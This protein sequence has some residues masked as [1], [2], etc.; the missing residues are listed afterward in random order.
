MS[1]FSGCSGSFTESSLSFCDTFL[2]IWRIKWTWLFL[3]VSSAL[4]HL[5][6]LIHHGYLPYKLHASALKNWANLR[7]SDNFQEK[8]AWSSRTTS[9]TLMIQ[10]PL[11]SQGYRS[12]LTGTLPSPECRS[13][14]SNLFL[15]FFLITPPH[16]CSLETLSCSFLFSPHLVH[17]YG[18]AKTG[19]LQP[20]VVLTAAP[21]ANKVA[22]TSLCY[23]V[24][25]VTSALFL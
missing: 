20:C 9:S 15:F 5:W 2:K 3:A 21:R 16:L 25:F 4:C 10:Q 7:V 14:L 18:L 24:T 6:S 22:V 17:S 23:R 1:T 19:S 12:V 13:I 8:G 11:A